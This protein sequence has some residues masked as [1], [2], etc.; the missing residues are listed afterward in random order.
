MT[1]EANHINPKGS[2]RGAY[3][4]LNPQY[5]DI[6][7]FFCSSDEITSRLSESSILCS[8]SKGTQFLYYLQMKG[9]SVLDLVEEDDIISFFI[10]DGKP[11]YEASYRYR[12]SEFFEVVSRKYPIFASFRDW[13]PYVRVTR[14][15]VQYLTEEEVHLIKDACIS[16]TSG[17]SY[18][19]RAVGM[20]LLY[21]G[22]RACDIAALSLDSVL[23]D[24]SVISFVQK[25]T[26]VP[27]TLPMPAIVGNA[28]F[29]YLEKERNSDSR[30]LFITT[31]G[32]EF[33]SSDVSYC[34][35]QIFKSIGIR[36]NKGDRQGTH[37]F[38]HHLATSLLEHEVA[39]PI[40]SQILGHTDPVSVQ[41]Y[42]SADMK[43]LRDCALSI[44]SYPLRWEVV[45]RA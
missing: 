36:Q 12:L 33:K 31:T 2:L 17:L 3:S 1:N 8:A 45:A 14:K 35:K 43:H 37:I 41:P 9:I 7:D 24:L 38:R 32:K 29:D 20:L 5:S 13:L 15:N 23:W 27:L 39:Q 11:A 42:L 26:S 22:M 25:K 4:K 16:D 44:D 28:V 10:K 34:V 19:C 40:I 30:R 18:C 21:T 6:V